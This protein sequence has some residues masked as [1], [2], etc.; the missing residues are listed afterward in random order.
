MLRGNFRIYWKMNKQVKKL[1]PLILTHASQAKLSEVLIIT[2]QT[3][4]KYSERAEKVNKIK[5]VRILVK[6]FVHPSLFYLLFCCNIY[7]II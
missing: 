1:N 4:G 3:E 2:T 7:Y 5:L 6:G